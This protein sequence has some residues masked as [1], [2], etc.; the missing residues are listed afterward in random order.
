MIGSTPVTGS[1][2][3]ILAGLAALTLGCDTSRCEQAADALCD[4]GGPCALEG[5]SDCGGSAERIADCVM[6]H[7]SE[8]CADASAPG[9]Q[10]AT[11]PYYL[12]LEDSGAPRASELPSVSDCGLFRIPLLDSAPRPDQ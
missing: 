11:S 4:C 2:L 8:A 9:S 10:P 7:L 5:S 12:C 6:N 1:R 3:V